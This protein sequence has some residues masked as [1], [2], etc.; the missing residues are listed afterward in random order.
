MLNPLQITFRG[1]EPL[2]SIRAYVEQRVAKLYSVHQHIQ[3][4]RVALESPHRHHHHGHHYRVRIDLTVPGDEIVVGC[5]PTKHRS[6]ED[7]Y[8]AIDESVDQAV[9]ALK[10]R[11]RRSRANRRRD[12]RVVESLDVGVPV[13]DA[14]EV[15][16]A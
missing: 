14:V 6:H 7:L 5:D 15:T 1:I 2:D 12:G 8:V 16:A 11:S 13:E 10:E 4:C 9:R 3:S